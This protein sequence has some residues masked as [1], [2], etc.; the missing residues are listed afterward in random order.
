[1]RAAAALLVA[2]ATVFTPPRLTSGDPPGLPAPTVVGGG[3]VLV[4]ATIDR[5]GAL[6]HPILLR[7]TPPYGQMVLD[8]IAQWHFTPAH[9]PGADGTDE[10]VEAPVLI[11]A[12]YRAPTVFNGPTLGTPPVDLSRAPAE[13][14][15]PV[16]H[17]GT[18]VSTAGRLWRCGDAGDLAR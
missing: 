5:S 8:A 12:V 14:P 15:Y 2:A 6:T 13:I 17:A 9:G 10:I 16:T 11:A 3:E 18:R 1:M 4:D 7:N